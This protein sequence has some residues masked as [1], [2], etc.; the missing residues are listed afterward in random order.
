ML[1]LPTSSARLSLLLPALLAQ[2]ALWLS[3]GLG[4]LRPLGPPLPLPPSV[5]GMLSCLPT[6]ALGAVDGSALR[7]ASWG[8]VS[9]LALPPWTH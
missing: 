3:A 5:S 1:G 8:V 7:G 9:K 4:E 2:Q 6:A